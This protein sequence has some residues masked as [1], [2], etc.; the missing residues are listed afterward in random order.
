MFISTS[1]QIQLN[2]KYAKAH[3]NLGDLHLELG[4][5]ADAER[6]F[7]EAVRLDTSDFLSLFKVVKVILDHSSAHSRERL[8][9]GVEMYVI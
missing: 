3:V 7:R 4:E 5:L 2:A 9:E 8:L 1:Q 6:H